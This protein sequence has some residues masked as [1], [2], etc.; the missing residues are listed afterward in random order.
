MV[1]LSEKCE[2][3]IDDFKVYGLVILLFKIEHINLYIHF[4]R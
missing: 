3:K 4:Y 2:E 1:T